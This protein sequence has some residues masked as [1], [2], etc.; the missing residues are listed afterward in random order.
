M[1]R[2]CFFSFDLTN[3]PILSVVYVDLPICNKKTDSQTNKMHDRYLELLPTV[4]FQVIQ[5]N[6]KE[7]DYRNL[8]NANL[9]TF[10]PVKYETVRY[11]FKVIKG[12]TALEEVAIVFSIINKVKDKATQISFCL[13]NFNDMVLS[14][15]LPLLKPL[16]KLTIW[17]SY[18]TNDNF[19]SKLFNNISCLV[20]KYVGGKEAP[21]KLKFKHLVSLELHGCGNIERIEDLSGNSLKHLKISEC[22]MKTLSLI[23]CENLHSFNYECGNT[24]FSKT[25]RIPRNCVHLEIIDYSSTNVLRELKKICQQKNRLQKLS[26]TLWED[27]PWMCYQK[28]DHSFYRNVPVVELKTVRDNDTDPGP[29]MNAIGSQDLSLSWFSLSNWNSTG[30]ITSIR[31]LRLQGCDMEEFPQMPNV[32]SISLEYAEMLKLISAMPRLI[33]LKIYLCSD[34]KTIS[35]CPKLR[36]VTVTNCENLEDISECPV[37]HSVKVKLCP[38]LALSQF[39]APRIID[40]HKFFSSIKI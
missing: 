17:E 37:V 7:K 9:V 11:T 26:L 28:L 13:Q 23:N 18:F 16:Q 8:V 25:I 24:Q 30:T 33:K 5:D 38:K 31:K 21:L 15:C 12:P 2:I 22:S 6:L 34:L 4:I 3:L 29:A 36:I 35:L 14:G 20:L 1:G 19:K 27:F 32:E 10:R 40:E 39:S